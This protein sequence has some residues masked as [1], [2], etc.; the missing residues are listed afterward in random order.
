MEMIKLYSFPSEAIEMPKK[1]L[2]LSKVIA[3]MKKLRHYM[4]MGNVVF[5]DV[6]QK[7]HRLFLQGYSPYRHM[8]E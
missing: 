4:S 5:C 3:E 7:Y 2:V 1:V 8:W 6:Y